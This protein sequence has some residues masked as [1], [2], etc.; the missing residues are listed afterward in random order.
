MRTNIQTKSVPEPEWSWKQ[1][2]LVQTN[3][4]LWKQTFNRLWQIYVHFR[5][6][7][8]HV[9]GLGKKNYFELF[10]SARGNLLVC[11]ILGFT[12]TRNMFFANKCHIFDKY[13]MA[14]FVLQ[15]LYIFS[16]LRNGIFRFG[17]KLS[18]KYAFTFW[19]FWTP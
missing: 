18:K 15:I 1:K 7:F 9:P 2:N 17:L 14:I 5:F 4:F 8:H 11:K 13:A 16:P 6:N 12:D 3:I 10:F 19:N